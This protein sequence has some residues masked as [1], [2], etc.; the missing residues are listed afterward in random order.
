[1]HKGNMKEE[2]KE[3]SE[4]RKRKEEERT[5]ITRRGLLR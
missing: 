3:K 1:M 2:M 5:Y 4:K